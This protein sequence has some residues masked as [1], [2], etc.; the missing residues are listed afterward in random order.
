MCILLHLLGFKII[1]RPLA[2]LEM[3]L[4]TK[5]SRLA[6]F[7][8]IILSTEASP[9]NL[10]LPGQSFSSGFTRTANNTEPNLPPRP[11]SLRTVH[12]LRETP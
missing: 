7:R 2:K 5:G 11:Q 3:S 10:I 9:R 1:P 6:E 4:T 8:G 12:D